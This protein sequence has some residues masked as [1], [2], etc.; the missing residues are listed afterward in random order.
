[1]KVLQLTNS[2]IGTVAAAS[3]M[4]FGTI[5]VNYPCNVQSNCVPTFSI[6]SSNSNTIQINRAGTYRIDYTASVVAA[7]A[8]NILLNILLNGTTKYTAT[9]TATAATTYTI[10][11]SYDVYVPG[12]CCTNPLSVPAALQIQNAGVALTSGTSNVIVTRY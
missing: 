9:V 4:P 12:N 7:D 3:Y 11:F 10:T 1:M 2:A 6:T 5:T 8:G